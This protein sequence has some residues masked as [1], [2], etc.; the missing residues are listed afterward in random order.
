MDWITS[1]IVLLTT[2]MRDSRDWHENE[3]FTIINID[4]ENLPRSQVKAVVYLDRAIDSDHIAN[5]NYQAEVGLLSRNIIV[6]GSDT[7][8]LP[9]DASEDTCQTSRTNGGSTGVFGYDQVTCPDK[10]LTGYGGHIMVHSGGVGYVEG[11]G[12]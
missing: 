2:A 7:D 8:S 11:V 12:K 5:P 1:A 10:H 9:T 6:Q 4:T 3:I